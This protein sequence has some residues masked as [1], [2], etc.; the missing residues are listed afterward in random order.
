VSPD[1]GSAVPP[2][3]PGSRAIGTLLPAVWS[4]PHGNS[5]MKPLYWLEELLLLLDAE[6]RLQDSLESELRKK[7][8][9]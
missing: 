2:F 7:E 4:F 8:N 9:I 3:S 5:N 1:Y 6:L